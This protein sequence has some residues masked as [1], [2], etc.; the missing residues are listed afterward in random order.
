MTRVAIGVCVHAEPAK[1]KDTLAGLEAHTI[2]PAQLFVLSDGPDEAI[3]KELAEHSDLSVL[4]TDEP[5]G[6]P[7]CFNRLAMAGD[8]EVV[9]LLESG[10]LV[11]PG[12]L[13]GLLAALAGD[14]RNGLA[15]P[16]TNRA[17]NEQCVFPRAAG[18]AVAVKRTARECYQRFGGTWRG[19]EPLHSLAAFC[20]V[21]KR[22]V[23]E[24]IGAAD[25]DYGV[26][27]CWE[28]DYNIRAA[29][30]G[31]KGVWAKG[32]YVYR[33][34]ITAR[35]RRD[36]GLYLQPNKR[37]YQNKFC[38]LQLRRERT[39]YASHCRGEA[40]EHFSPRE[41]IQIK[42][43]F[44]NPKPVVKPKPDRPLVSCV[45][46]TCG[47]KEFVLQSIGYFNRQDYPERELLILDDGPENIS[48]EIPKDRRIRYF[49]FN[50]R[51]SIG[52]KRNMGCRLACGSVI[53]CWDDDDWYAPNRISVQMKS[54]LSGEAQMCA[55]SARVFF[56]LTKWEFWSCSPGLHRR[57]WAGDVAAGTLVYHRHIW[58]R[59]AKYPDRSLAEDGLFLKEAIRRGA[60]LTQ[61]NGELLFIYLRHGNN[62]WSFTCGHLGN[63]REWR[64]ISEPKLPPGDRAFY[65]KF[66]SKINENSPCQVPR[67]QNAG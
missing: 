41:L 1:F 37:R 2:Q 10:A 38:A 30:A 47:R 49:H 64:R 52:F 42:I 25:E 7:A 35:Q 11:G 51:R 39:E 44:P 66:A 54:L 8:S 18:T 65:E 20:Y 9:V 3:Q 31:F 4:G 45:M 5:R 57:L 43:P 55:L 61:V 24:T 29:R 60:K 23:F 6:P 16:S 17:W 46:P 27:P 48:R 15:G 21:V 33:H 19:L 13:E 40:C 34:P 28:M 36:E 12:W 14:P 22:E 53:A 32:A 58:E 67:Q 59:L 63:P 56:D 62:S 26:G 50:K